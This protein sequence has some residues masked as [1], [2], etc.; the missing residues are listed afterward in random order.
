MF[1]IF[2]RI[3]SSVVNGSKN[4]WDIFYEHLL[5]S[6]SMT[7][8]MM[9][10]PPPK[11][12]LKHL[13][14]LLLF[15]RL[16]S[17]LLMAQARFTRSRTYKYVR[18][19][20]HS[21]WNLICCLEDQYCKRLYRHSDVSNLL[22]RNNRIVLVSILHVVTCTSCQRVVF[23]LNDFLQMWWAFLISSFARKNLYFFTCWYLL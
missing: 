23:V 3:I 10:P 2:H 22:H 18:S 4:S 8:F 1:S 17:S 15:K 20:H 16:V 6:F 14:R 21:A 19:R 7:K 9:P 5:D 13:G 12:K 11:K